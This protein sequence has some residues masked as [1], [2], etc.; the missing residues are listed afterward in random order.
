MMMGEIETEQARMNSEAEVAHKSHCAS[1]AAAKAAQE[2]VEMLT[3]QRA[4]EHT[5]AKET[6]RQL[7][8]QLESTSAT[9]FEQGAENAQKKIK[10]L[11]IELAELQCK[12]EVV[13]CAWLVGELFGWAGRVDVLVRLGSGSGW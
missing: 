5:E 11:E 9:A 2:V 10:N 4:E 7:R 8:Y 13:C 6:E 3:A 1:S 12:R